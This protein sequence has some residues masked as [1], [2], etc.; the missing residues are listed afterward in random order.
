M[1]IYAER[2]QRRVWKDRGSR[3]HHYLCTR[4]GKIWEQRHNAR[5]CCSFYPRFCV[6]LV[7][8]T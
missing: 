4:G 7:V 1:Q 5:L 3:W 6:N 8:R 2:D